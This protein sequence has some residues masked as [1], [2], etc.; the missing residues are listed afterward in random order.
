MCKD[1]TLKKFT[2]E[3]SKGLVDVLEAMRERDLCQG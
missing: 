3:H 1:H 2:S